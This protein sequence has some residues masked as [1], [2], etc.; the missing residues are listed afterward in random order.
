MSTHAVTSIDDIKA[1][2]YGGTR[3]L[4]LVGGRPF[5]DVCARAAFRAFHAVLAGEY[6]EGE[7]VECEETFLGL[8]IPY[9]ACRGLIYSTYG[10]E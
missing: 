10:A 6:A 8:D 2:H 3:V 4:Y 9:G 5:C 7:P 1:I